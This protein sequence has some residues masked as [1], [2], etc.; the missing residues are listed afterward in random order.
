MEDEAL[1]FASATTLLE[2]ISTRQISPVELTELYLSRIDRLD[3]QLNAFLL[4]NREEALKTAK[5]AEDVVVR[6]GELGLL[7]GLPIPIKDTQMT[8]GLRTT[9]GSLL[10][11]NRVPDTDAA[12][13][14][15][16]RAAG[17][18]ILGKTNISEFAMVGTCEN[19]LGEHGRNP[20]NTNCTP[21][22][23]SGGAAA[24]V[25]ACLCPMAH[26]S[27]GGGS[28]RIPANF[29]GIYAI[30][31]TQGRVSG[32]S[33]QV[34]APM[35]NIF[36]QNGPLS[37]TVRDSAVFLQAVAGYD[38]RDPTSLRVT[39]PDFV[40]AL[41]RG[42]DGLRVAW[43]PDFGFA[44]V[45]TGVLEVTYAATQV[46]EELGCSVEESDLVIDPPYDTFGA[47]IAANSYANLGVYLETQAD[48]LTEVAIFLLEQGAKVTAGEYAR[49]LGRIDLLKA[50]MAALF[51][52][53]DLLLS[54]TAC[55][56]AFP[57]SKFPGK[58]SPGRAFPDQY[59]NGAFT[60]PINVIGH[61]A[62]TVPAGFSAEGLPIGL[63]IVGRW[64]DEETVLAASAAFERV[65]PWIGHRPPVS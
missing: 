37:R 29:C 48:Q 24:A 4:L 18:I 42:V 32:Y 13:V 27:D 26:G 49:A 57:Y 44:D 62:A 41:D 50:Y 60:L 63:Q 9:S 28:L 2:L 31:P 19:R 64:G 7:H 1:A 17:G 53:Y 36:G 8:K 43:T 11:K 65:R 21:G 56:P 30:K 23:S 33:G 12:I 22:G 47:I 51:E 20:W 16:I 61:P 6:G 15:D 38:S 45:E 39:P 14:E 3:P 58:W 10:F 52:E 46:F 25:A 34:E 54:P 55:F 59:W 40:S 35:P 5:I